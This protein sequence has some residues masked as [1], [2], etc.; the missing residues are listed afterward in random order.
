MLTLLSISSSSLNQY[1][2]FEVCK[3]KSKIIGRDRLNSLLHQ[4]TGCSDISALWQLV[5]AWSDSSQWA[6][7]WISFLDSVERY[8]LAVTAQLLKNESQGTY[9]VHNLNFKSK[10]TKFWNLKWWWIFWLLPTCLLHLVQQTQQIPTWCSK[11]CLLHLF[12]ALGAANT[13]NSYLVQETLGA[14]IL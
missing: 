10:K 1:L 12:A 13:A 6:V 5:S 3:W 14:W 11:H 9:T 4:V 7:F 8:C 2:T